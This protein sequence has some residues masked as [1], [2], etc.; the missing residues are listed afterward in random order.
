MAHAANYAERVHD[1]ALRGLDMAGSLASNTVDLVAGAGDATQRMSRE[2]WSRASDVA[3]DL[4][5]A[6]R[7]GVGIV[8]RNSEITALSICATAAIGCFAYLM[9]HRAL[10]AQE[11]V[12]QSNRRRLRQ[13]RPRNRLPK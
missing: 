3:D 6:G 8:K 5:A 9:L 1:T 13:R 12:G 4:G 10:N 11:Q 7:A 2:I